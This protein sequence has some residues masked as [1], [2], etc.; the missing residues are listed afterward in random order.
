MID[1]KTAEGIEI[2]REKKKTEKNKKRPATDVDE[3]KE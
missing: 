3:W 1:A 2:I